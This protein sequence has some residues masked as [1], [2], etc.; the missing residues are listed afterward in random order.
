[1]IRFV[2]KYSDYRIVYSDEL[3]KK[4]GFPFSGIGEQVLGNVCFSGYSIY[5][6][7]GSLIFRET[8]GD[9]IKVPLRF[10]ERIEKDPGSKVKKYPHK[11][12]L[13]M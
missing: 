1:M 10:V 7:G 4:K 9:V 2:R 3:L 5:D 12:R 13:A 8:N 6:Y 11:R